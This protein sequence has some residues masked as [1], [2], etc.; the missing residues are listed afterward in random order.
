MATLLEQTRG[1]HEEMEKME[2][3]IVKDFQQEAK[4][5]RERL[6]QSH[7]VSNLIDKIADRA[8]KLRKLYDDSD[9]HRKDEIA[10]IGGPH[11][12]SAFYDRVREA[13]DYHKRYP[14]S[15]F[16]QKDD[17]ADSL[18]EEPW[19]NFTG[20]ESLGKTLDLHDLYNE[21]VN[22]K[23]GRQMEYF[24][25]LQLLT[26]FSTIARGLRMTKPY[27]AYLEKLYA[28]LVDFHKRTQ[29]LTF[30]APILEKCDEEFETQ[31]AEGE[32]E[33]WEDKGEGVTGFVDT[34]IDLDNY[35]TAEEVLD[36]VEMDT[37]KT[38][39][40]SLGM[41][42]GGTPLQRA[43]RLFATK[44]KALETLDP[45]MFVKGAAPI[46]QRGDQAPKQV[47]Q[48][49]EVAQAEFRCI[50]LRDQLAEAVQGTIDN[51]EKK[52]TRTHEELLAELEEEEW[53]EEE[54]DSD[55][56]EAI[57][58]PLKLPLGFDG[59]PIPYWLYKLHGLNQEFK[60][61]ICGNYSYWG[62]RAYERHFRE[63]RHQHGMRCLGVPNTKAF[64]EVTQIEDARK[65]HEHLLES[66]D[67]GWV[68]EEHEEMEDAD[69]NVYSKKT[70]A[71]LRRQGL[72]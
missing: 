21:Y 53:V 38:V 16:T 54:A 20:E 46:T 39:L 72:V 35:N 71:D 17:P 42:T 5:H 25:Y 51:V 13:R 55:E 11:V 44:G 67:R 8:T 62:R 10:S 64:L 29:P 68:P 22:S 58:N 18:K 43:E 41:K 70:F 61:E 66:R 59:K 15:G 50:R 45:K 28:Y 65:L 34:T 48:A 47:A 57:Y 52:L 36:Q 60:C 19:V 32:V 33:G 2:R 26:E 7:R 37:I 31:W 3:L 1:Y 30:L 40:Q 12:F 9:G 6:Y 63:Q 23:F 4:T 56:E 49:K 24:E 69:G 27:K 14:S